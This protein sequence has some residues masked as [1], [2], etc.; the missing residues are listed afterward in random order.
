MLSNIVIL[1]MINTIG[2][3]TILMMLLKQNAFVDAQDASGLSAL[4]LAAMKKDNPSTN[5]KIVERLLNFGVN[6]NAQIK[7]GSTPLH[8]A[9]LAAN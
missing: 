6:I 9:A 5:L 8:V 4:H 1:V 3:E 2:N 7:D